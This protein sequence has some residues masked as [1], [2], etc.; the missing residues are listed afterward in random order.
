MTHEESEVITSLKDVR[1]LNWAWEYYDNS[2][3]DWYQ[4]D[5][6]HC[7]VIEFNW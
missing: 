5:C 4:F 3:H 6:Q 1:E 2:N 7:M